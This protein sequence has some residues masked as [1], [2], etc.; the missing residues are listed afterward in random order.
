MD[1]K[2]TPLASLK[3]LAPFALSLLLGVLLNGCG[4]GG[5]SGDDD[6]PVQSRSFHM[7]F[8]PFPYNADPATLLAV[9]DDVYGKI[10]SDADMVLH[11]LEEGIPWNAALADDLLTPAAVTFPYSN[12]IR[13]DWE[14]RRGKT[15]AGHR[16]YIAITPINLDRNGLAPW[17]DT[18]NEMALQ[19]PFDT[20]A[21]NGDFDAA[22]VRN[23]YLN[24]CLR[25]IEYFE[26]DYLA[27][28]IEVNLLRRNTDAA[29]WA[30]YIE[31]HEQVYTSL[32]LLH[33]DLPI[34]ASVLPVE[35]LSGYVGPSAEFAGDPDGYRNS[36]LAALADVL[37]FSDIY[38]IS[39][40]PF[41]TVYF[42]SP[43][44]ADM[45]TQIFALSD[46][47]KAIAETGMLAENLTAAMISFEGSPGKQQDY[48]RSLLEAADANDLLFVNWFVLQDYDL[49]CIFI[50]GCSDGDVLWRDTGVYDG[51]GNTRPSHA[52]W[53]S[54]LERPLR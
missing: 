26:P 22:D 53:K 21:A 17:R 27:I 25:V 29:T 31:L 23:A 7:G 5:S 6:P 52:T 48:L 49:F 38:G 35:M 54:W 19:P 8:T 3:T 14:T 28:G 34:F 43:F 45:F 10:E 37:A 40:Y 4:G 30:K 41:M 12:H 42:A 32:K 36:Q 9:V 11:H 1:L 39:L 46:K 20:H 15:P 2:D 13:T 47:P 24:Y 33:P 16:K 51:A 18:A 44:P 50:G